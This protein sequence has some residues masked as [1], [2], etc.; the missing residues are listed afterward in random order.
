MSIGT[1]HLEAASAFRTV[2]LEQTSANVIRRPLLEERRPSSFEIKKTLEQK[3]HNNLDDNSLQGTITFNI[4][5]Y[6]RQPVSLCWFNTYE[7]QT[8]SE[9]PPTF[10]SI[11]KE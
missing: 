9:G 10:D 3:D 11:P 7:T 2:Y 8:S 4:L 1:C 6:R 5:S